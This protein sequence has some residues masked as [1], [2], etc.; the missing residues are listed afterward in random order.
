MENIKKA[1]DGF[2][3]VYMMADSG[4]RGSSAQIRQLA[5]MRGLMAKPDGT[6]IETPIISN[7]KEGLNI[8]EYFTSTHGARKGLAD[9]ALKTASAGYLT[10][11]LVDISQNVRVTM[12]DCGTHDGVE[13]TDIKVG[14]ELIEDLEERINGRVLSEDVIDP[15][16]NEVLFSEGTLIDEESARVIKEAEI[17][18]VV[19]RTPI[20]CKAQKGICTKCY[21][22]NLGQGDIVKQGEAVGI[23]AAQSIGEPGTQLT[24]RTFH[25]G[26][27]AGATQ[28]D[29]Q[30]V[31]TKEGFIRYYNLNTYKNTDGKEIV[32]NR[33]NAAILLVEPKVKAPFT[34]TISVETI[35]EEVIISVVKGKEKLSYSLRKNDIAKAN[36]LAGV[37]GKIDGKLYLP[38]ESGSV[39]Q[40]NDSIVEIISDDWNIPNRIPYGSELLVENGAPITQ[41]IIASSVGTVKYYNLK[42]DYLERAHD[43]KSGDEISE[44]GLFA[45]IADDSDREAIRHYIARGSVIE[46]EDNEKVV[47]DTLLA[48]PSSDE[49][50]VVAVWDPYSNPIISEVSGT[51]TFEDI[52]DGITAVEKFDELSGQTRL[53]INEY[54]PAGYKPTIVLASDNGSLLRYPLE[55]KTAVYVSDTQKVAQADILAKTPKAQQKSQD[56]TGGLPRVSELFEARKPKSPAVISELDGTISFG[57]MIRKKERLI[58]TSLDGRTAEYLVESGKRIL[59]H[60]GEF[61]HSGEKLTDGQVSSHDIL[62]I[63]GEK[64]LHYYLVSEVQQVYR[65]QGVGISDKHIEVIVSQMLRQVKII[66]SGNTNFIAGDVVSKKRFQAENERILELSGEPAI[67]EPM[68]HGIT[69]AAISADSIISA[70]SFQETTKVLTEAAIN[71][72]MDHLEDLKEN[73][74]LGRIIPVGTGFYK[75]IDVKLTSN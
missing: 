37:S 15:I 52:I 71:G 49:Q 63:Q 2:N 56:I 20:T 24:L 48:R 53:E 65:S 11:K 42:G 44:K 17:K 19:I 43:I 74:T 68:L 8:L 46:V 27:V 64:A 25:A 55:P 54:I 59:V 4:A 9:T 58:V 69:R 5:G 10:R 41:K 28:E 45:V 33:R 16:T 67:A 47:K 35:H 1:N 72:K 51:I 6:I 31:A 36:E 40:E 29:K 12:N 32:A 62:R 34:G 14:N 66:D 3:S 75:D 18:S 30:I 50:V 70:A 39:V 21:G 23:V 13:I 73:V 38:Y 22:L 57:K 61:V 26:G 7:F 60:E